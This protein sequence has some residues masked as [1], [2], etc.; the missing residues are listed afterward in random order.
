M[1][2]EK[3]AGKD[4]VEKLSFKILADRVELHGSREASAGVPASRPATRNPDDWNDLAG[5]PKVR[6]D[7]DFSGDVPF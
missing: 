1:K 4:G 5:S 6:N 3:Y 7:E 2:L